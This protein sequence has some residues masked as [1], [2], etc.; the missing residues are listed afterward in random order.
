MEPF[1]EATTEGISLINYALVAKVHQT[2]LTCTGTS[3][4]PFISGREKQF[5][6][7]PRLKDAMS[8]NWQS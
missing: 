7:L 4:D 3:T 5:V 2:T 8:L 6:I 1:G